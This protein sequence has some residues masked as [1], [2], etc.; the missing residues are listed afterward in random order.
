MQ[1]AGG[2]EEYE[3]S[4]AIADSVIMANSAKDTSFAFIIFFLPSP[5]FSSRK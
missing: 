5:F 2:C 1:S 4:T 3:G